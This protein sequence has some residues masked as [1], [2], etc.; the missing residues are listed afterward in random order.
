[1]FD[2]PWNGKRWTIDAT[3]DSPFLGHLINHSR[4]YPR[5]EGKIH[6]VNGKPHLILVAL[7]HIDAGEEL[8]YD[9]G[10]KDP[11][12]I[13]AYPW[14]EDKCHTPY[15]LGIHCNQSVRIPGLCK[16]YLQL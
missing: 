9:Y 5:L 15:S 3:E 16:N 2:F 4:V 7:S 11:V 8:S 13:A 10:E 6:T 14:L 12:A 1:M